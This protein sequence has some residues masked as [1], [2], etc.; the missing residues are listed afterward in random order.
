MFLNNR[1]KNDEY[2]VRGNA[3][4]MGTIR[5][6]VSPQGFHIGIKVISAQLLY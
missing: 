1:I 5:T 2:P 6:D 4:G 3:P